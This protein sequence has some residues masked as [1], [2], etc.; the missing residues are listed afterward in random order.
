MRGWREVSG[1]KKRQTRQEPGLLY[2]EQVLVGT[3]AAALSDLLLCHGPPCDRIVVIER[4]GDLAVSVVH[5]EHD[6]LSGAEAD[7]FEQRVSDEHPRKGD[8]PRLLLQ[9]VCG[10]CP[11]KCCRNV[12]W[13]FGAGAAW[14]KI[15]VSHGQLPF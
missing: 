9:A 13:W 11:F 7:A 6:L 5:A 15:D 12:R 8:A 14:F 1:L 10:R 3:K 4:N 2:L